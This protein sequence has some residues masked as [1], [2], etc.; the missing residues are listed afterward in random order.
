MLSTL[1]G[2]RASI[3]GSGTLR[4]SSYFVWFKLFVGSLV[5]AG[6]LGSG[7][8][9]QEFE[10]IKIADR[11]IPATITLREPKDEQSRLRQQISETKARIRDESSRA[12]DALKNNTSR[13][14]EFDGFFKEYVFAEMTQ[15]DDSVLS[16]LGAKREDFFR[17]YMSSDKSGANRQHLIDQIILPTMQRIADGNFHPAVRLNAVLLIG[18]TNSAEGNSLANELPTPNGSAAKYLLSLLSREQLPL[19]LRVGAITGLHR[20]AQIEGNLARLDGADVKQL[21]NYSLALTEG[22]ATGQDAWPRDVNYWLQRRAVQILGF[23]RNAGPAGEVVGALLTV[24]DNDKNEF[25]LRLDAVQALGQLNY[26]SAG[27]AKV[28]AS[29]ESI[30]SFAGSAML[31]QSDKIRSD[32]EE[33]IALNLL[34]DGKYL[35]KTGSSK[36][37]KKQGDGLKAGMGGADGGNEEGGGAGQSQGDAG[38][39]VFDMPNYYINMERRNCKSYTFACKTTLAKD[40]RLYVLGSDAEKKTIDKALKLL[41]RVLDKSDVGLVDIALKDKADGKQDNE[42]Q[43]E[44]IS[45]SS[46]EN[47]GPKKSVAFEMIELFA[48]SGTELK[49]LVAANQ[50]RDQ[51]E[52]KGGL[53]QNPPAADGVD[54]KSGN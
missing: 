35:L 8:S 46:V 7:S 6:L 13:N 21:G 31:M 19:Y 49:D 33:F 39:P 14:S 23:L 18:M 30:I 1:F 25:Y 41:D 43:R 40:G 2:Q 5:V 17:K 42:K 9:A 20:V 29:S 34:Y 4:A 54:P 28:K 48:K 3:G 27:I 10:T 47:K 36:G 32:I 15:T 44:N 37:A 52:D 53:P 24:L 11:Y 12:Q 26:A 45:K 16:N 50:N 38:A 22:K 51:F